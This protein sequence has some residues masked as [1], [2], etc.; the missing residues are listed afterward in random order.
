MNKRIR[1]Q[2]LSPLTSVELVRRFPYHSYQSSP[3]FY[4]GK[5]KGGGLKGLF[6][7][8]RFHVTVES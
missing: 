1:N 5:E 3:S 7:V 8:R 2:N 6:A 4:S